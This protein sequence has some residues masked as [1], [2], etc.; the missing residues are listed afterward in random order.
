MEGQMNYQRYKTVTIL[1][2]PSLIYNNLYAFGDKLL[3]CTN[4]EPSPFSVLI[5]SNLLNGSTV[6]ATNKI[7]SQET[8][9]ISHI[10]SHLMGD[11]YHIVLAFS[12][13]SVQLWNNN[14][15]RML[16]HIKPTVSISPAVYPIEFLCSA[17]TKSQ[18][19]VELI[20]VGDTTGNIHSFY[21]VKNVYNK[22]RLYS[23]NE[24]PTITALCGSSKN[25]L[26]CAGTSEGTIVVLSVAKPTLATIVATIEGYSF[27]FPVT[28]MCVFESASLLLAAYSNGQIRGFKLPECKEMLRTLSEVLKINAHIRSVTAMAAH[29]TKSVLATVGEDSFMHLFEISVSPAKGTFDVLLVLS[30]RVDNVLLAGVSFL[31]PS[32]SS[33]VAVG[34]DEAKAFYWKDVV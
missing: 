17:S 6:A 14:G 23:M 13:S 2:A 28:S 12:G 3:F 4:A 26:L 29:P 22:E 7:K 16:E 18:N 15:T 25:N 19:N 8:L 33:V 32:C 10:A 21:R 24:M 34:Y 1:H 11:Q 9:D 5:D 30:S 31:P 20:C 27:K